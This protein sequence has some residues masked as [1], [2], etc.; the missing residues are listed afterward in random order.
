MEVFSWYAHLPPRCPLQ[1]RGLAFPSLDSGSLLSERS[2]DS[3]RGHKR[4]PSLSAVIEEQPSWFDE[5]LGES[6]TG[7][8]GSLHRRS[9]S[10]SATFSE[11]PHA[12][13]R[14]KSLESDKL[15]HKQLDELAKECPSYNRLDKKEDAPSSYAH[16]LMMKQQK[17]NETS[18]AISSGCVYGPNS[19]RLKPDIESPIASEEYSGEI[20]LS[21]LA[22]NIYP[23]ASEISNYNAKES[24]GGAAANQ[25]PEV[26]AAKR[27]SGQ[28][29]RVRKLQYIAELERRVEMLQILE[30]RLATKVDLL[31]QQRVILTV[32]NNELKNRIA[33][34]AKDKMIKDDVGHEQ[35]KSWWGSPNFLDR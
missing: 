18:F 17:P 34:L 1:S 16:I 6:E 3:C 19:P 28:R 11:P 30:S 24:S 12:L 15:I 29:S 5:L 32:E 35:A 13:P 27:H 2:Q 20:P 23:F 8:S 7:L 14:S 31:Y 4:S 21:L 25:D 33:C 26:K 22:E 9:S 10:D